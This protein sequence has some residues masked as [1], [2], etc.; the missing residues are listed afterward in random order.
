MLDIIHPP[1]FYFIKHLVSETEVCV[2]LQVEHTQMGPIERTFLSL[3][4]GEE[5]D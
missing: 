2:R 5:G 4:S 3:R 1:V